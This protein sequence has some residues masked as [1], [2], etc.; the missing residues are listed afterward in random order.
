MSSKANFNG[1]P[2]AIRGIGRN[3]KGVLRDLHVMN[4]EQLRATS[5]RP[6][7]TSSAVLIHNPWNP[8]E[9][10][11]FVEIS[12]TPPY[13]LRLRWCYHHTFMSTVG[14]L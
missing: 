2:L 12:G 11:S 5:E 6:R 4:P 7:E 13:K 8:L 3:P 1:D 10:K 9:T 14:S